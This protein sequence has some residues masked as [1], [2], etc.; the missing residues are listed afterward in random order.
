MNTE[1]YFSFPLL[2]QHS[3]GQKQQPQ[4]CGITQTENFNYTLD[5][6]FLKIRHF[7]RLNFC[8]NYK[9]SIYIGLPIQ[10]T[11][12]IQPKW[13]SYFQY[14]DLPTYQSILSEGAPLPKYHSRCS[15]QIQEMDS[16]LITRSSAMPPY[17]NIEQT[18]DN[19][20]QQQQ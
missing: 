18:V 6:P 20:R 3:F 17:R 2:K 9:T 15:N 11:P 8:V 13:H 5:S 19:D 12:Y 4:E 16:H 7:V 10:L 1:I 14:E